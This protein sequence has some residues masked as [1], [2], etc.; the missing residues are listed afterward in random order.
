MSS[1]VTI[2]QMPLLLVAICATT[3]T[4]AVVL[5]TPSQADS[6]IR[7]AVYRAD[8]VYRIVGKV[9]YQLDV[10]FSEGE[11]FAG[12]AAG[13]VQGLSFEAQDNH[14]F[15]KPRAAMV[16][17]N[18]TVLTNRH[19]Y[20]LDYVVQ[21]RRIAGQEQRG[22]EDPQIYAL[23]F[24]YPE[25]ERQ[26]AA[27]QETLK[28]TAQQV[29]LALSAPPTIVNTNYWYCGPR[30]IRPEAVTD[31]GVRTSFEFGAR[32][33]LPAI[34]TRNADG[35]E[36]LVNFTVT[37]SGITVH[38]VSPQFILRRGRLVGCVVNKGFSGSG[39]RL[40][41]GTISPAVERALPVAPDTTEPPAR[42]SGP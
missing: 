9:G 20:Y 14:L 30:S 22:E 42:R 25:E 24:T 18:L 10:E 41:T 32:T 31:D 35:T 28:V 36:S 2:R 16:M 23:R 4:Q 7:V 33:E 11:R 5:P 39:E 8:E 19:H 27:S 34:F 29:T 12:M 38:R 1:A 3:V 15:L 6:R 21:P 17:T 37:K 40:A 26:V 13:D